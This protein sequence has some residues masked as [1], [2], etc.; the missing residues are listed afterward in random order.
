MKRR[1]F[2]GVSVLTALI[3]AVCLMVSC[4]GN[5]GEEN[6]GTEVPDSP[7]LRTVEIICG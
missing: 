4:V 1:F 5:E 7:E 6:P 2:I 3:I